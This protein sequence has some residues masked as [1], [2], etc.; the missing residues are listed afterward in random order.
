ITCPAG[1]HGYNA[2]SNTCTPL[3]DNNHGTHTSGTIGARGNNTS[4]VVGVNW[5]TRIM[6][7]KFLNASGSGN[8]ADAIECIQ[9]A[10]QAK[11]RFGASANIRVLSNSW[12]GGGFSQALL[13]AINSANSSDMLFVAAAGN[14][15]SNNNTVANYPSNYN[16]PNVLAVAATDNR[17]AKSSFSS[18]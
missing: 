12:G 5:T 9:F 16:A 10:I 6:G 17:D 11:Q 7:L 1:S 4:G 15:N 2:V 18:F 8:T 13:D 14:S 3:D